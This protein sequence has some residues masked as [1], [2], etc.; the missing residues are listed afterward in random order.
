M[1]ALLALVSLLLMSNTALTMRPDYI[2]IN[3]S[4][5]DT[6][7]NVVELIPKCISSLQAW[8]D[9]IYEHTSLNGYEVSPEAMAEYQQKLEIRTD[10]P[11]LPEAIQAWTDLKNPEEYTSEVLRVDMLLRGHKKD[12]RPHVMLANM[13]DFF[14]KRQYE[15]LNQLEQSR[16]VTQSTITRMCLAAH[17]LPILLIPFIAVFVFELVC[18]LS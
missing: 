6:I 4:E 14:I 7:E 15:K 16:M 18:L 10:L 17:V 11:I 13:K 9:F 8:Q 1:I 12:I 2:V 3:M 5:K